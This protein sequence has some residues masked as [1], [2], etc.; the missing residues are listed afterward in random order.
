M[1]SALTP[2]LNQGSAWVPAACARAP[3]QPPPEHRPVRDLRGRRPAVRRRGRQRPPVRAPVR[4]GGLAELAGTRASRPTRRGWRTPTSSPT[5][6]DAVLARE[7]AAHWVERLR[8]A[9]VPAGPI[10]AVDEAFALADALGLEPSTRP[11]PAADRRRRCASTARGRPIRHPPPRSTSTATSSAP[12][13]RAEQAFPALS[14][15]LPGGSPARADGQ[16]MGSERTDRRR[17]LIAATAAAALFCIVLIFLAQQLRTGRDPAIGAG[18]SAAAAPRHVIVRRVIV[19]RVIDDAAPAHARA[20]SEPA[21]TQSAPAPAPAPP[22]S[23]CPPRIVTVRPP[24]HRGRDVPRARHRRAPDRDDRG[25]GR[26]AGHPR[27]PRAPLALP[28]DLRAARTQR[29]PAPPVVSIPL[30]RSAVRAGLWAASPPAGS[31]IRACWLRSSWGARRSVRGLRSTA[32][33]RPGAPG[34]A[35]SRVL[36]AC[37]PRRRWRPGPH[38]AAAGS[39]DSTSAGPGKATWPT[40]SRSVSRRWSLTAAAISGSA[41]RVRWR[42]PTPALDPPPGSSSTTARWPPRASSHGGVDDARRPFTSPFLPR[43]THGPAGADPGS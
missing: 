23:G 16:G 39:P 41:A 21:A 4:G 26:R 33:R 37:H 40:S 14:Q 6:C 10:N 36:L 8:D 15:P 18:P 9:A 17:A 5:R 42:S 22:R 27:L 3:R 11:R 29:R 38:R 35:R 43:P 19:T 13:S 28:G 24:P 2:L 31:S 32:P 20:A 1:D 34:R 30:L 7:A 12:G 25:R